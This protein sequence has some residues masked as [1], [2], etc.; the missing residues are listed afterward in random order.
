MPRASDPARGSS[1]TISPRA[2]PR[3]G[4]IAGSP[5]ADEPVA[6]MVR[7]HAPNVAKPTMRVRRNCRLPLTYSSDCSELEVC[8][9][10]FIRSRDVISSRNRDCGHVLG[11]LRTFRAREGL[12]IVTLPRGRGSAG[13]AQP[14]QGWGRGFESR[15]PLHTF[16][17]VRPGTPNASPSDSVFELRY[18]PTA[19]RTSHVRHA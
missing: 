13:R 5:D 6:K 1:F 10:S 18:C 4:W 2:M 14:C 12:A 19:T 11:D 9:P 8:L 3:P 15:R 17:L 16:R 7:A